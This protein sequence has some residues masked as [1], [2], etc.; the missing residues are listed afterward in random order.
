MTAILSRLDADRAP[1]SPR[2]FRSVV[3][4]TAVVTVA[5]IV[6]PSNDTI[7][8][9]IVVLVIAMFG[10]PTERLITSSP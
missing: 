6:T 8:V 1:T 2:V 4:I 7:S 10:I 5:A 9:A 3:A